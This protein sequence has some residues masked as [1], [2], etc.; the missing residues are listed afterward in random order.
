MMRHDIKPALG[1]SWAGTADIHV[2]LEPV[3]A[4]AEA[5]SSASSSNRTIRAVVQRHIG[6]RAVH[7]AE[8]CLFRLTAQGIRDV[9]EP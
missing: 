9:G 3:A 6:K 5:S 7:H 2:W 1:R 4:A 8:A